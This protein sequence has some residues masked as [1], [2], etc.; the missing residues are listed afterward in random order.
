[1]NILEDGIKILPLSTQ[2]SCVE[3]LNSYINE[4]ELFNGAYGLVNYASKEELIIKHILDSLA[5]LNILQHITGSC[6]QTQTLHFADVGSGAGLPGIPLAIC[7]PDVS[8]TLIERS[9]R[10]ADFLRNVQAVLSLKNVDVLE[11]AV[12]NISTTCISSAF[13][14]VTF[15][16]FSPLEYNLVCSIF[17]LIKKDGVIAAYKGKKEK[18]KLELLQLE[19]IA[20]SDSNGCKL[21]SSTTE[22]FVPFLE[23]E[24]HIVVLRRI[25]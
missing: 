11:A 18:I 14:L 23:E 24:R 10:R 8:F 9:Q 6:H 20:A 12:E 7:L 1:M 5:P 4:I 16:A 15:R 19:S 3:K 13:D 21:E 25:S 17:K 2:F 22:I